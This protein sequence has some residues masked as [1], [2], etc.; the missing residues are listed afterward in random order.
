MTSRALAI[1]VGFTSLA[2]LA[3]AATSVLV[4]VPTKPPIVATIDLERLFNSLD[5]LDAEQARITE[6]EAEFDAR[7]SRLGD[8]ANA[9]VADLENFEQGGENWLRVEGEIREMVSEYRAMEK[10]AQVKIEAERAKMV[11]RIYES[12]RTEIASFAESQT[13]PI[14]YILVDDSI[15]EIQPST[16]QE[17]QRQISGRRLVYSTQSFDITDLMLAR[18]NGSGG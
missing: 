12:I 1:V 3:G 16:L 18:M 14:D 4:G 10:F 9:L 6:L 2:V 5:M 11:Q 7:I 15:P 8:E 17:M 13:P